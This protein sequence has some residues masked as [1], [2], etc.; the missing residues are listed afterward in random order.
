MTS[1]AGSNPRL[2]F[3]TRVARKACGHLLTTDQRLCDQPFTRERALKLDTRPAVPCQVVVGR[4]PV[5]FVR[6]LQGRRL[7]RYRC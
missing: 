2:A 3:L 4:E 5:R 1:A 6:S 7:R